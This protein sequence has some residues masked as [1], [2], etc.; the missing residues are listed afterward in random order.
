MSNKVNELFNS[1]RTKADEL[2]V[3]LHLAT[4]DFSDGFEKQKSEFSDWLEARKKDIQNYADSEVNSEIR[5]TLDELRVRF[6]LAKADTR[7][8]VEEQRKE[9]SEAVQ[10]ARAKI[11]SAIENS[12]EIRGEFTAELQNGLDYLDTRLDMLKLQL[13]LGLKDAK[14]T[15]ES[16]KEEIRHKLDEITAQLEKEKARAGDSFDQFTDQLKESW[17]NLKKSIKT[18]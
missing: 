6:N 17:E 7:D 10:K 15:Y 13:N 8:K 1:F 16:K 5:T 18:D 9:L 2:K 12:D 11:N 3:Q 14:D 4:S